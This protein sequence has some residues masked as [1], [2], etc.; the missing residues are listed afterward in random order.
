M[1]PVVVEAHAVCE[2]RRFACRGVKNEVRALALAVCAHAPIRVP[3]R[4]AVRR[5]VAHVP[6][7]TVFTVRVPPLGGEVGE[8]RAVVEAVE[9]A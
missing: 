1:G 4:S 9:E 2:V 5:R 6:R 8:R 7:V 3:L